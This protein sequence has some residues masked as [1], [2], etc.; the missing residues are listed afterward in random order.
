MGFAFES[1]NFTITTIFILLLFHM[2]ADEDEITGTEPETSEET[3][4]EA[5]DEAEDEESSEV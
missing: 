5:A 4:I 1:V 3:E 2:F